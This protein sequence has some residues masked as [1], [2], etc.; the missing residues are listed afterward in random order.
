MKRLSLA[1]SL[2]VL[3]LIVQMTFLVSQTS[4]G[5]INSYIIFSIWLKVGLGTSTQFCMKHNDGLGS[6]L[7]LV[8]VTRV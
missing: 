2:L 7:S 4:K 6:I 5:T 8:I 3:S 1:V